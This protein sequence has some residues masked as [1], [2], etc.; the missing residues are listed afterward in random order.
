MGDWGDET[1]RRLAEPKTKMGALVRRLAETAMS[2]THH[3]AADY[4]PGYI[5]E[6]ETMERRFTA[7]LRG[8]LRP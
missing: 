1:P 5:H 6:V 2:V 8:K 7:I 4:E 3:D